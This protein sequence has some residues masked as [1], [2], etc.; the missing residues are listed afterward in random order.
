MLKERETNIKRERGGR[1]VLF[2]TSFG[3][4]GRTRGIREREMMSEKH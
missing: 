2:L 3:E 1:Q 4:D